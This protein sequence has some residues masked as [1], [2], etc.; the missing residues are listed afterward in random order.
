MKTVQEEWASFALAVIPADAPPVQRQEMRRAFYAGCWSMLQLV[1]LIGTDA[2]SEDE[3][4]ATL[5]QMEAEITEFYRKVKGGR[6]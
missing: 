4:V 1:K 6:A 5:E 2:V 3:G